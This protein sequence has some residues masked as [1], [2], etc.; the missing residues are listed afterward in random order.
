[1]RRESIIV[2][3]DIGTTK[4]CAVVGEVFEGGLEIRG[5]GTS[6]STGLRKGA[7]VNIELTVESIKKAVEAAESFTGVEIREVYVCTKGSHIRGINSY[8]AVGVRGKEITPPDVESVIESASAVYIPLDREVLHVIPTGYILDGQD[9]IRDPVGMAGV[10]LEAHVH[11]L[12][13]AVSSIQNLIKCCEKADLGVIEVVF[14]PLASAEAVL[15]EEEK[16][17]G[18]AVVDIG[19]GTTDV[20]L[21]KDGWL[22]HSSVLAIGGNHFTN[23]IAVG[24]RIPLSEAERVKK[25]FGCAVASMVGGDDEITFIQ[26]G[27]ERKIPRTYLSEIIQPRAEELLDLLKSELLS[28]SG[29]NLASSGVVLT[30]GGSLLEGLDRLA[31]AVLGLPVRIGFP[32]GIKGSRGIINSPIYSTGVGLLLYGFNN[33]LEGTFY[34]NTLAGIFGKVKEW[35]TGMLR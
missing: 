11:I 8:G 10:R 14:E 18:V 21:Y 32:E 28:C 6:L 22:R 20:I 13:G 2:G 16:E 25:S 31:E 3:L 24:L 12:T 19:G 4:V 33:E 1:M 30:G 15:I 34:Q 5:V 23:D 27:Q 35:L 29:Y 9:G 26:G 17:L 7:I